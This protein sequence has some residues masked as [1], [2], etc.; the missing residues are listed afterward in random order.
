VTAPPAAGSAEAATYQRLRSHLAYLG[1]AAAAEA[2]PA[3]LDATRDQHL[4][5]LDA[6]EQLLAAEAGAV[7]ARKLATRLQFACLPAPW[8]IDDYDF[9]AQPGADEHLIRKL[10]TLR[11]LGEA[12]NVVLIG[13][14]GVGKTMLAVGL[15]RAAAEAGH[16][17]YFTTCEQLI[18]KPQR[19]LAEH[20]FATGLRFFTQP[21]LLVIDLCRPC[22]YADAGG[23]ARWSPWSAADFA[24][25]S[26]RQHGRKPQTSPTAPATRA[27]TCCGRF[28]DDASGRHQRPARIARRPRRS[29]PGHPVPPATRATQAVCNHARPCQDVRHAGNRGPPRRARWDARGPRDANTRS[30]CQFAFLLRLVSLAPLFTLADACLTLPMGSQTDTSGRVSDDCRARRADGVRRRARKAETT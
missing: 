4:P 8:R 19:A 21:R 9:A 12:A 7:A 1:L 30:G 25:W 27:I 23:P 11:F 24:A 20:R 17:A 28:A 3:V 18:R 22:N 13:P 2:L 6:L 10:A 15:A 5:V 16:R 14:P 29:A 26:T